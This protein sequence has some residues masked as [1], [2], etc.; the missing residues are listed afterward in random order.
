MLFEK[1][2]TEWCLKGKSQNTE[3][4]PAWVCSFDN[5]EVAMIVLGEIQELYPNW[6]WWVE[7]ITVSSKTKKH[8]YGGKF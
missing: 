1:E 2:L 5:K 6:K 3:K 4:C 7:K 8:S